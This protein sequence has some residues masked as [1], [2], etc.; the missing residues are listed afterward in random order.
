MANT[1]PFAV[2]AW[3]TLLQGLPVFT[4]LTAVVWVVS[5]LGVWL[6]AAPHTLH[7]GA[8]GIIFGYFGFLLSRMSN[9]SHIG[10]MTA[11]KPALKKAIVG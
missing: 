3:L 8:S 1:L 5:G 7:V 4:I 9:D 11:I 6:F 10:G 2:L